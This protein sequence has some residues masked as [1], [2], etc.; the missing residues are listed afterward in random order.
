MSEGNP[1]VAQAQS[2]TT[3]VTGIGIAESA[4]DLANGVSDGSWVEAGLGAV[5]VGLE[6]L[7]LVVDPIGTLASYG[8][9]WLIEHVQPLKEALDWLAGDP[10][11]IQSFSETWANVAAEVN[12]IAG[13]L[14]NEVTNGTAGWQGEGAEAYRGAAAEQADAL[15]GAASLADGI[16]AGVMIMGT[17]VAAVRELVRDLVAELVGKLITWALEAAATLGFATPAIA[18]Q[19]TTA[20][21]KTISKIS[22]FIRKLVKTIGNVSPKIRKIIDKLGEI[23][24][25]LSKM[26]R[27][28][29][30]PGSST[31]PSGAKPSTTK[32]P[33][34]TPNSPD[35]T[36]PDTDPSTTDGDSA[37]GDS[38]SNPKD[39]T[40]SSIKE[41]GGD[42]KTSSREEGCVPG[43]G[44]PVDLATGQM[45]M[46]QVDAE[47]LGVLPLVFERTHFSGYRVGRWFGRSWASTLDQR[48]E[49]E[50]DGVYFADSTG[51]RLRY[52]LPADG[53]RV[54]PV[55]GPRWPLTTA[56]DGYRIIRPGGRVLHF[57]AGTG[58]RPL[59][60]M[61]DPNGN[62]VDFDHDE[63][64]APTG[65]R[66]SGGYSLEVRTE[67]GRVTEL[68]L[69]GETRVPLAGYG[70]DDAGRLTEVRNS[71]GRA[72]TFE[73][74]HA[75]RIVRWSDRNGQWYAYHY[76]G[77]GRVVRSEGSGG[78]L[79]G[80]WSY[81]RVNR[82]TL[83]TDSLGHP[84]TYFFN[85]AHQVVRKV[86]ALGAETTQEWIRH[87]RL[88]SRTDPLGRT[89]R[90][91]YD[92]D[93]NQ[94][95]VTQPDGARSTATYNAFGQPLTVVDPDGATWQHTY[96]D[97]GNL[98][99]VTD[100]AGAVT[101]TA[102]DRTGAPVEVVDALGNRRHFRN[103]AAGLP[104]QVTD[105]EGAVTRYDYDAFGRV[106]AVADP[107]GGIARLG[108]TVEGKL[109]WRT[110]PD[111]ATERWRYDAEG[112]QFEH[113]DALGRRTRTE[114]THFDR[115][116]AQVSADGARLEFRYD[117]ELRLA[118]VIN[119][120]GLS[121][122]Y[123]RDALGNLVREVDFNGREIRYT[124]DR[125]GGLVGWT[126][127]AGQRIERQLDPV[128][129]VLEQRSGTA[130]ARFEY[131]ANGRIVR[132]VN[133]DAEVVFR[134]DVLGRVV[135][136]TV[137]GRTVSSGYDAL[138]R[139]VWRTGPAGSG[140]TWDYDGCGRVRR[141]VT[142]GHTMSF[143]YDAAGHETE[144]LLDAGT[145]F[146]Q[147]WDAG[148][149]L[150]TQTVSQVRPGD[151]ASSAHQ[152]QQR[153]YHYRADGFVT[154]VDD[155]LLGA[156]RFGL[157]ASGR[158]TS[159]R[160]PGT[161]E[162]YG[163]DAAGNV[164]FAA[165]T[166]AGPQPR[167]FEGTLVRRAGPNRYEHD[168]QGRVVLRQRKRLSA[169]PDNWHYTWDAEDR[170]IAVVTP[171]A[172]R[173]RYRYD[174]FGRRIA[175]QRLAPAG[176]TVA[177]QLDFVWDGSALI[178]QIHDERRGTS[179]E[180][181]PGS[182]RV[183]A[184]IE[185]EAESP[186]DWVDREFYSMV[187][188]VLGT[189]TQLVDAEGTIAWQAH[190]TLWGEA[191]DRPSGPAATPLRFPGQ[192]HDGETGLN[193]SLFRFYD[194]VTAR[195]QSPDP[196]GLHPAPN[197]HAY[198]PNPVHWAD[199]YGL[200]R[201]CPE[202]DVPG[203]P[204]SDDQITDGPGDCQQVAEQ[205]RES[206]GAGEIHHIT[207][208]AP[209]PVLGPYQSR[210]AEWR[211]HYAVVHEGRVYDAFTPRNGVPIDEYKAR[212]DYND[213][214]DFGF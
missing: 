170:L 85:E 116:L 165:V 58:V 62:R 56:A 173:W 24:E 124:Y 103:N 44:D 8:V 151:G 115:P 65:I 49:V 60:A 80:T 36:S 181:L 191:L 42:P 78:A 126:N 5:G 48:I 122:R 188:D 139:K 134:R 83:H 39:G 63:T 143:G 69:L 93:G 71:S 145:V 32:T 53:D 18:V 130:V 163:Y 13:D 114:T 33:D 172:T 102:H 196:L 82:T 158:V 129:R 20:I 148:H 141:L 70:Y 209:Y 120:A 27:K 108:W 193:Y 34:T 184:Q 186:Q 111:G 99:A 112:H 206:L 26:L 61:S 50:P 79:T 171:D 190:A 15:A 10:P 76:D 17:V 101:R 55:E 19:A 161:Q 160:G 176:D 88:L 177:E 81:D 123:E 12:A 149:R 74:D 179:W 1:L 106:T 75:D 3:G 57:P 147:S 162:D 117:S 11:V 203:L 211:D 96:D 178:G 95:S 174:P 167:A 194:P 189:P 67:A 153:R 84:T 182:H 205:I 159:V 47:L 200:S 118:E 73:Y 202:H 154:A 100:P 9:S 135:E 207:P 187:T 212:F 121:W 66:H 52:P 204:R 6:V 109:S 113:I 14:G 155:Q 91:T 38:S 89:T 169:K 41:N 37:A 22:D 144:R 43:S 175:K 156:R 185:R 132:A 7:S 98:V 86:N 59:A 107:L 146:A 2:Q 21:T 105:A 136:E 201:T 30:K 183:L 192:Y 87:D 94:T 72:F 90:Y 4:V 77:D 138:G 210:H 25:K 97:R 40:N 142:A 125:A 16:S 45:F 54:L 199:P 208:Q 35:T 157:T 110:T 127:G 23:I 131:D 198:V 150:A 46:G 180:W 137:N 152:L 164:T 214:I 197:H 133:D 31:T 29:G 68:A 28:G 104:V 166:G 128:G 168:G 119:P 195:F 51:V 140:S 92:T 213:V 64:G